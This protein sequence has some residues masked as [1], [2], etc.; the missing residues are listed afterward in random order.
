M[1]NRFSSASLT[2]IGSRNTRF[3]IFRL[4]K[5]F[6]AFQSRKVRLLGRVAGSV[7]T[8]LRQ[9]SMPTSAGSC[10]GELALCEDMSGKCTT[11][12]LSQHSGGDTLRV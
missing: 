7:K 5:Y 11:S 10:F 4:G 9:V 1:V 8:V 12:R 3:P 2:C 6:L